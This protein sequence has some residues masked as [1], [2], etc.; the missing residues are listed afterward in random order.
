MGAEYDNLG[1]Q[2]ETS[3]TRINKELRDKTEEQPRQ[4]TTL[5]DT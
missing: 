5:D 1:T 3:E 4:T 2:I